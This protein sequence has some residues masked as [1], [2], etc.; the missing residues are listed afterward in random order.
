M[1]IALAFFGL[2]RSL[3]YTMP[4]IHKNIL[5][6]FKKN[7]IKYDIF[8]HTYRV[9]YYENKR[10]REKVSHIN[11]DEYKILAPIYFQIDDLDYVKQC[12]ALSQFRTHP[13]P[14]NTNYQSVD[15]FILAQLSKSHVTA[16]IKGSKNKYDYVIYLRP[17]VEYIT[18]FDLAYFKR[19]NDRTIC[20]PDFHRY[21]PQLFND[22]FCIANGKTYLQY[23]DT[24]PYLLEISKR[25]SLHSETVLGNMMAKYG[26]RFAY[27]PFHFIR[28]RYNGVKEDRDVKEFSKIDST[29]K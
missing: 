5:E 15:N 13:D 29:K 8:L 18:P 3:S 20:I 11:N 16:L 9:D 27:I 24:F 10:S 26:L 19:V 1:K 22:R 28:I 6:I 17:D 7:D 23:G 2:T 25:E 14:W 12:L 4:S 21:G